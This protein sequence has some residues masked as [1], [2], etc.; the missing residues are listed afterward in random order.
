M[1][2]LLV[3]VLWLS[4]GFSAGLHGG[5][6]AP[7]CLASDA[8]VLFYADLVSFPEGV[9]ALPMINTFPEEKDGTGK[10]PERLKLVWE[11]APKDV[12]IEVADIGEFE[13]N[14]IRRILYKNSPDSATDPGMY[15]GAA[16]LYQEKSGD[17]SAFRPFYI[18][19]CLGSMRWFESRFKSG[20]KTP[21]TLEISA[22]TSGNGIIG[23]NHEFIFMK[24]RAYLKRSSFT[25]RHDPTRTVIRD[26][27]GKVISTKIEKDN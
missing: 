15:F 18:R 12:I 16:F 23:D 4:L 7:R 9:K 17:S 2:F 19:N 25:G 5:T 27:S 14:L 22:T 26:S 11:D 24:E 21:F 13:G 6:P 3:S 8:D 20:S 1:R 10:T